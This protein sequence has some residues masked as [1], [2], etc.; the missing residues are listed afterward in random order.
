MQLGFWPL[1]TMTRAVAVTFVQMLN[2]QFRIQTHSTFPLFC[3][4]Y[5][6][7]WYLHKCNTDLGN[8]IFV[9]LFYG[10]IGFLL[11]FQHVRITNYADTILACTPKKLQRTS[12]MVLARVPISFT[13]ECKNIQINCSVLVLYHYCVC[14]QRNDKWGYCSRMNSK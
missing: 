6:W 3:Y 2:F 5:L 8:W 12:W 7:S 10:K 13:A 11:Q 9:W 4:F 1:R 14:S